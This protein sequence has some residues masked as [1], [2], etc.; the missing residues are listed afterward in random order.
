MYEIAFI[1][2][3]IIIIIIIN[4]TIYIAPYNYEASNP[5]TIARNVSKTRALWQ[6]SRYTRAQTKMS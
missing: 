6:F 4:R 5:F 3:I 2:I 1:I